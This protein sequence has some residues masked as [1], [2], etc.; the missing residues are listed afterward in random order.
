MFPLPPLIA[1]ALVA[2]AGLAATRLPY[3]PWLLRALR[4]GAA[5]TPLGWYLLGVVLGPALGLLDA[6][7]L[8]AC[9]PALACGIG[10]VAARAGA[11]LAAPPPPDHHWSFRETVDAGAAWL[12]PAALLYAAAR[13][14]P[15][16]FAPAWPPLSPEVVT[17]A[18]AVAVA[19]ATGSRRVAFVAV[20]AAGAALIAQ[21]PPLHGRLA[22]L[23]RPAVW[24][25]FT[26]L[27]IALTAVLAD[28]IARRAPAA[29][30]GAI[31]GV[32]LGAGVG[33]ATGAS[34]LIVCAG[35]GFLL[36]RRSPA[37]TRLAS[38]LQISEQAVAVPLWVAA[39]AQIGVG[40]PFPAVALAAVLLALWPLLR[41]R[42]AAAP[43]RADG[44]LGLAVA[45][46]FSFTA[47]PPVVGGGVSHAAVV[48]AVALAILLTRAINGLGRLSEARLTSGAR[49]VEVSV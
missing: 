16:R 25:A 18:A 13:L 5:A 8:E 39:G 48:T 2:V 44:S 23:P 34:P 36:A 10:W 15:D 3:P 33:L 30:P 43:V 1:V 21:L 28:R 31:A 12:V 29:L 14:L 27:G 46:S 45:L 47:A 38:D 32:C 9:T 40:G 4:A 19:G 35:C 37:F 26:V 7:L 49:R 17:L 11:A 42:L 22:G 6:S 20:L 24:A 41:P